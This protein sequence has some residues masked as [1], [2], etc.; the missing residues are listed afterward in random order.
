MAENR[1]GIKGNM[2]RIAYIVFKQSELEY[3]IALVEENKLGYAFQHQFGN[4]KNIESAH[5]IAETL[6]NALGLSVDD[7]K[8]IIASASVEKKKPSEVKAWMVIPTE[9]GFGLGFARKD[10]FGHSFVSGKLFKSYELAQKFAD[11]LNK[12]LGL[13]KKEV[14]EIMKSSTNTENIGRIMKAI[15][16]CPISYR[17]I[18]SDYD[19][20]YSY[21][22]VLRL[23]N[24]EFVIYKRKREESAKQFIDE[25][26][27]GWKQYFYDIRQDEAYPNKNVV[28]L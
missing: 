28:L 2:K 3:K 23:K 12:K 18:S 14:W 27:D 11:G 8:K 7:A 6:N 15:E 22:V 24:K 25:F 1:T 19:D 4:F 26:Q 16:N 17:K 10:I 21:E 20:G 13:T 9:Q 5:T